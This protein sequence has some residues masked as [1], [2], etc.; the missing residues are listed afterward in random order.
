MRPV[1]LRA[2]ISPRASGERC[3][4]RNR[5]AGNLCSSRVT[6]YSSGSAVAPT[7]GAYGGSADLDCEMLVLG[8]GP[9]VTPLRFAVLI[10]A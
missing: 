1:V 4:G 10:S 2:T 9:G 5:R 3:S 7:A 6:R 8:A